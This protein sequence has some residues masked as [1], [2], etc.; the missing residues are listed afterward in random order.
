MI[1][2]SGINITFLYVLCLTQTYDTQTYDTQTYDTHKLMT[3]TSLRQQTYDADQ[4]NLSHTQTHD[5]HKLMTHTKFMTHTQT[6][7]THKIYDTHTHTH[8]HKLITQTCKTQN[9][10]DTQTYE[11]NTYHLYDEY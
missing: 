3:H 11:S 6:Y 1:I 2:I 10:Q 5:T 4:I 9:F 8:T 7:D